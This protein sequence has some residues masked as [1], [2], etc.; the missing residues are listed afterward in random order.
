MI[1]SLVLRRPDDWHLH[2]RDGAM[3]RAVLP[4]TARCFGRAI[5]MPNLRVPVS[6]SAEAMAYRDRIRAALPPSCS[7]QPLMACYL[8]DHTDPDALAAG[9]DAGVFIAAKLYPA[10][11]TTNSDHGV[12]DLALIRPVLA[13]MERIAMPLLVHGEVTDPTVDIFDREAVFIDRVLAPLLA[14]FPGLRV[15]FEHVTTGEAVAF[16]RAHAGTG[17]VAATVTAHHL[18]INR[19]SIFEGGIRPHLYCLPIAKRERHRLAL[20]EAATSGEAA[21]FL[22][23]D[24]AP[25]PITA[26]ETACGCA[27]LFTAATAIELYAEAFDAAGRLDRL[28]AFASLNGPRFYG[29]EPNVERITLRRGPTLVPEAVTAEDGAVVRPFRAG[30]TLNWQFGDD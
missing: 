7:F 5:V 22:G 26:K 28:E 19:S 23:T 2:L 9:H 1:T 30:S 13:R 25:H 14:D 15:V 3:L 29:L 27:G 17:R 4:W 24:S 20:V 6:G 12:T 18:L 16:V 11:A 8:T 10:H 21:F